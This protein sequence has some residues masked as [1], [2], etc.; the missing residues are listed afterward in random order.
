MKLVGHFSVLE[1][2]R[3]KHQ[4]GGTNMS[5]FLSK[6]ELVGENYVLFWLNK[7]EM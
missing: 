3:L 1:I 7:V 5:L 2:S 6:D 4:R